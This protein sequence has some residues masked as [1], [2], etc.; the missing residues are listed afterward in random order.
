MSKLAL[1]EA[2][3]SYMDS[4]INN[5]KNTAVRG[6]VSQGRVIIGG[7]HYAYDT[8]VDIQFGEGEAVWCV[9][10]DDGQTAVIVGH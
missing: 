8:A 1:R 9:I 2:I 5:K 3:K 4:A 6:V 10:S 7:R